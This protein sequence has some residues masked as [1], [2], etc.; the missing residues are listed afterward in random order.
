MLFRSEEIAKDGP[1][2][3]ELLSTEKYLLKKNH[4]SKDNRVNS[5]Q[6]WHNKTMSIIENKISLE[7]DNDEV[8]S[9]ITAKQIQNFAKKMLK[10]GCFEA[11]YSEDY[12]N[13]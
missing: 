11:V 13:Q 10:N 8:I 7:S 6:Y 2:A 4:Q 3:K 12:I 5:V 9:S 1:S